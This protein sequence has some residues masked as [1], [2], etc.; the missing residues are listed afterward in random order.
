MFPA[1]MLASLVLAVTQGPGVAC[2][3][4]RT[5][6]DGLLRLGVR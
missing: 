2:I 6:R 4:A 3:V 5:R 1:F